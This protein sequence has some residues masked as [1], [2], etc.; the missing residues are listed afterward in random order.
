[1]SELKNAINEPQPDYEKAEIDLLRE[2]LKRSYKERFEMTTRLYKIR[3]LM[4]KAVV[5]HKPYIKK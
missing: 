1:M 4:Q 5:S 3:Q 2:G